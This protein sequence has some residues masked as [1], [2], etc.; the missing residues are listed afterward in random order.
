MGPK[1]VRCTRCNA[2]HMVLA[3]LAVHNSRRR[4]FNLELGSI[5]PFTILLQGMN[6]KAVAAKE[7]KE[8]AQE[9]EKSKKAKAAEDAAWAAAGEGSKSKAQAKKEEQ[10]FLFILS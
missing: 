2:H 7:K 3:V 9:V 4:P 1:K 8:Q 6:S 10:V 5:A